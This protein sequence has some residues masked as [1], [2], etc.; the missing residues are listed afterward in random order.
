VDYY[1]ELGLNRSASNEEIRSA[2]HILVR[3][4]H[5][6]GQSD[7]A[8]R[9]AA[10]QQLN[11]LNGMVEVLLNPLRR[12]RYDLSLEFPPR[13][14]FAPP[15][16]PLFPRRLTLYPAIA[17]FS[18]GTI[19]G[20][21]IGYAITPSYRYPVTTSGANVNFASDPDGPIPQ[22]SSLQEPPLFPVQSADHG[23]AERLHDALTRMSTP[24]ALPPPEKVVVPSIPSQST[25]RLQHSASVAAPATTAASLEPPPNLPPAP[26]AQPNLP[27]ALT[28]AVSPRSTATSTSLAGR[29][30]YSPGA[31]RSNTRLYA[32]QYIELVSRLDGNFI[33][34]TFRS[35]YYVVNQ[36]LSPDVDFDFRGPLTNSGSSAFW[37]STDGSRGTI[38]MRLL[39]S[40]SLQ[41]DW[42]RTRGGRERKLAFG[43]A[44]LV[45][46]P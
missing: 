18:A 9:H 22:R 4:L 2:Y 8:A 32:P 34:G 36:P 41:V 35:R 10:E 11:R 13:V 28:D 23:G 46:E 25:A 45:R 29:W 14:A 19:L 42:V 15:M 39:P 38:S 33:A 17:L 31:G 26:L 5:P 12:R 40:G 30:L 37:V 7:E 43:K 44:V 24:P 3:V 20:C 1:E 6:D 16:E 27:S 21:I